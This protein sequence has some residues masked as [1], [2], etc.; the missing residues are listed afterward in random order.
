MCGKEGVKMRVVKT[1][2]VRNENKI[3]VGGIYRPSFFGGSKSN[4]KVLQI[5]TE[6]PQTPQLCSIGSDRHAR[7]NLF[8]LI[9]LVKGVQGH[10]KA[11]D[12]WIFH[13]SNRTSRE[14]AYMWELIALPRSDRN[15]EWIEVWEK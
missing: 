12:T 2:L 10:R 14:E 5:L 11:G 8:L 1:P 3:V 7:Y 6:C 13:V 4:V 9:Q 15:L